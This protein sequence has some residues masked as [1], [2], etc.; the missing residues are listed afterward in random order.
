M[1]NI[2]RRGFVRVVALLAVVAL[3][4]PACGG[5][6]DDD[7]GPSTN[8]TEGGGSV[9]R[10]G[11]LKLGYGLV[12]NGTFSLDPTVGSGATSMDPLWYLLYG[13]LMRKLSDGTLTPDLADAKVV[14]STTIEVKV[15]PDQTWHDGAPFD[16]ESVKVGLDRNLQS[17]NMGNFTAGFFTVQ[18]VEVVDPLTVR[19]NLPKGDAASWFDS[20]ISGVQTSIT[21]PGAGSGVPIGA[22]PMKATAYTPEQTLT[23]ERFD[24]FWNSSEVNF[25]GIEIV[26]AEQNAPQSAL[27]ALQSGQA[28]VV[29]LGTEQLSSLSGNLE[30]VV[31]ADPNRQ[32]R[33]TFCKRDE[34]LSDPKVRLAISRAIDR[35][36]L[37]AAIFAGTGKVAV[38]LWPEGDRFYNPEVGD[39][40]GYDPASARQLLAE[41]G[42]PNPRFDVYLLNA[43][44]IPDVGQVVQAQLEAV[45]ITTELKTTSNFV[46]E[47]LEPKPPGA[48]FLPPTPQPGALRLQSLVG[49]S[50]GNLC[51]YKNPELE[52]LA[53]ELSKVGSGTQEAQDIWWQI[54]EIVADQGLI[55]PLLFGSLLGGY[56]NSQLVLKGT[57]PEGTWVVPDIYT[58]YMGDSTPS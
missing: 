11:V 1:L 24:D 18:S 38:Q 50:I 41:A 32:L 48:T 5:S 33:M 47:F 36:A 29:T 49:S 55:A 6:D 15:R 3:F 30:K 43:F 7:A 20:F 9:N 53:T 57:Y 40:L 58:S 28:D 14:D 17:Q 52:R 44:D 26:S 39:A 42:Q 56:D 51:D 2:R 37:N 35:D 22:G 12:Q 25:A 10:D 34:P 4:A 27:A 13:R 54:E 23:L 45:G 21:R 46:A 16:A 31:I 19:I 8:T